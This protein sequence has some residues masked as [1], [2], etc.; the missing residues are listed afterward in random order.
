MNAFVGEKE[1]DKSLEIL[2]RDDYLVA[3]N[4]PSGLLV[5]RSPVDRREKKAALQMLRD[6]IGRRVYPVHRLDRP[7]SGVLLFALSPETVR[8]ISNVF[9]SRKVKK[10]YIAVVRGY[11]PESGTIDHP[12]KEVK[13]RYIK[14]QDQDTKNKYPAI[15]I[16]KRLGTIEL[17]VAVDKY[18]VTRYSLVELFPLTGRRHQL[19]YHMK[20]ISH[21]IIGDTWYGKTSHN[22]FFRNEFQC[23]QL[24]LCAKELAIPHPETGEKIRIVAPLSLSFHRVVESFQWNHLVSSSSEL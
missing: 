14:S 2:Y 6:Q 24:L 5:H 10:R 19:R 8:N 13:D 12:V 21:H 17:P 18:P 1:T 20:H 15:T 23:N 16:Y 11:I 7:T 22:R 3:V 9:Q 4:K